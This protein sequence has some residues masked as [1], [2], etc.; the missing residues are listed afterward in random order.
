M[1]SLVLG[2]GT[3]LRTSGTVSLSPWCSQPRSMQALEKLVITR[4]LGGIKEKYRI[5]RVG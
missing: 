1:S 4:V 3:Q 5:L 2:V